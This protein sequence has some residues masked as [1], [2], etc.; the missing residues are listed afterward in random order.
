MLPAA[1]RF[2][3]PLRSRSSPAGNGALLSAH[4]CRRAPDLSRWL[5]RAGSNEDAARIAFAEHDLPGGR[6][7]GSRGSSSV[8]GVT[9]GRASEHP[10]PLSLA[11]LST[12]AVRPAPQT[13]QGPRQSRVSVGASQAPPPWGDPLGPTA[14]PVHPEVQPAWSS[15]LWDSEPF[16]ASL[17]LSF[18]ICAMG[19]GR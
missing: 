4:L 8:V 5:S 12:D 10:P 19:L 7:A 15:G 11:P 17:S 16:P 3:P 13:T 18:F 2:Q 14:P 9:A 1:G 6:R